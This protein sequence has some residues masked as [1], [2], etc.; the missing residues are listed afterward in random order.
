MWSKQVHA[1]FDAYEL[2]GYLDGSLVVPAPT[3]TTED[4]TMVNQE[5][6]R[7]K[8]QDK[9]VYS[10]LLGSISPNIQPLLSRATTASQIWD[11]LA[12]TYAKPSRAHVKQVRQQLKEW[13]K[14]TKSVDDYF[15][16][17]T[18]RFDQLAILGKPLEHE[19][20]VEF[21]LEG[22]PEDYKP[23]VDQIENKDTPP[24][25]TEIHERLLN[26]E[27]KLQSSKSVLSLPASAN[28]STYRGN[29]NTNNG[30]RNQNNRNYSTR[31]NN[32]Q[33]S[34]NNW[35][36]QT[37]TNRQDSYSPRPYQGRCQLCSTHGHSARRCPQFTGANRNNNTDG[38]QQ[39]NPF[40]PWQPRANVAVGPQYTANNWLLDSGATHHI[41]SDLANL[42]LHQPYHGND[43]VLIGDGSGLAISQTG[44]SFLPS[45]SR[46]LALHKVLYVPN[47]HKNLISVYRLCNSNQVSVEFFPAHF[48]VKD[49]STGVPFSRSLDAFV[50]LGSGL[51]I[52]ISST[53]SQNDVSSLDT[54]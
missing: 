13:K 25:L 27:A 47:I 23:I 51:T 48:Q 7:W 34:N 20:Q 9:L 35:S 8:R 42:S 5:H 2:A 11:T 18:T 6:T 33:R 26:H 14:E 4:T 17:L 30:Q 3:I 54:H 41:T 19:D 37:Y 52:L 29:N 32:N 12:S 43:E 31:N 21:I 45:Y 46:P 40:S 36:P 24:S 22:L 53:T 49:L 38:L 16:G 50:F 15:Q 10:A 39:R 28:V 44:S 1:L